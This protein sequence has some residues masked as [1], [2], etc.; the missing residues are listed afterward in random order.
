MAANL[1]KKMIRC[2]FFFRKITPITYNM[3]AY[4][5]ICAYNLHKTNRHSKSS[6]L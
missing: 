3:D 4:A 5:F 1:S 2:K 6:S